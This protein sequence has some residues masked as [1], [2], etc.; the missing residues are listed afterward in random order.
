MWRLIYGPPK[1]RSK[2]IN[3]EV[4][5]DNLLAEAEYIFNNADSVLAGFAELELEVA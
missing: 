4:E 3:A 2:M 1:I 5:N